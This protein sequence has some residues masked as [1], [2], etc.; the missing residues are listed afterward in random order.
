[1]C[2][3]YVLFTDEEEDDIADIV[4]EIQRNLANEGKDGA[5]TLRTNGEIF[6]TQFVPIITAKGP[7][8]MYWGLPGWSQGESAKAARPIINARAE[9]VFD[10]PS[11]RQ[12]MLTRRCVIP[13]HGFFEW[14]KTTDGKKEKL[15]FRQPDQRSLF[16]AGLYNIYEN[17][18]RFT[19]L[20]TAANDSM[21]LIHDRM[22]VIILPSEFPAFFD[23]V[24][25]ARNIV[26]R[27]PPEL[28]Y[29]SIA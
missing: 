4:H 12:S 28:F 11:F 9:T 24:K 5:E 16:M 22:P 23:D 26:E 20:T 21:H 29:K 2:G 15:L 7:T 18:L 6:P 3:R 13:S 17:E 25:L 1:M 8:A 27:V 14:R 19:I 10:K